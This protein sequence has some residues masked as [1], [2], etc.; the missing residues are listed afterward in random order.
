MPTAQNETFRG[1]TLPYR[2]KATNIAGFLS[3]NGR[4]LTGSRRIPADRYTPREIAKFEGGSCILL[5]NDEHPFHCLTLETPGG[6]RYL[7]APDWDGVNGCW[8][9][10]II[11]RLPD[12]ERFAP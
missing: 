8:D 12:A 6:K 5:E 7:I 9:I 10:E 11:E 3:A 4:P 2:A 1:R